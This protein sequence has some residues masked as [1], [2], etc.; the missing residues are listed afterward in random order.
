WQDEIFANSISVDNNLSLRGNL[1]G[2]MPARLS[3]GYTEV[4][5][6]LRTGEF[7]RT[8]TSLALNPSFFDN[9]LK[10]NLN[11]N[12]AWQNNR[13]ADEGAIG[14]AIRFDP[15]QSVY[16]P[17]SRLGGY[18]EWYE[19]DGDRVAVGAQFNPVSLL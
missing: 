11:A 3:V 17:T 16:D 19:A 5:G 9:H 1:F 15:T 4:P 6:L 2:M 13:F 8:T 7:K 14:N 12:I 18:F 10:I